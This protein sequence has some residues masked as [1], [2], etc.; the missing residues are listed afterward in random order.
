MNFL[1]KVLPIFLFFCNLSYGQIGNEFWFAAPDLQEA[2]GD[3]PIILRF[4]AFEEDAR[5]TISQPG[6]P[7]F[8]IIEFSIKKNTSK[9]IDLTYLK[10]QIEC[11]L[12][13]TPQNRGLYIKASCKISCYYDIADPLN[14][15]IFTLK[16]ENALGLKFTI[17][18][19][20]SLSSWNYPFYTSTFTILATENNTSIKVLP[21]KNLEG[22]PDKK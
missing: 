22:F 2:H 20:M 8:K 5:I 1:N 4:S 3:D 16:G 6:N 12:I 17:P 7:S 21:T 9:S 15:D 19:Q 13:N 14:G 10:N 18:Q 11:N